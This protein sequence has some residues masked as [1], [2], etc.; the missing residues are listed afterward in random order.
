MTT[1]WRPD[2]DPDTLYFIT[3]TAVQHA[4]FFRRVEIKRLLVDALYYI[5]LMNKVSLYAFVVMPNHVH[6]IVQCPLTCS[7][8]DWVRAFKTS[9]ARLLVRSCQVTDDHA[10][11]KKLSAAVKRPEKQRY[12]VWEDGYLAKSVFSPEFLRQKMT[13]IHNNPLQP[14]WQLAEMAE[15]Y[16]WSSARYYLTGEPCIIPI[17]DVWAEE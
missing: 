17:R 15:A 7:F 8:K 10:M 3:T 4:L 16:L 13:Y 11:L 9:T 6:V 14:H 5:S 12:K 2:F 1:R